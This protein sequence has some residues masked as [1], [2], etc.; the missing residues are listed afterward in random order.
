MNQSINQ[1]EPIISRVQ[2]FDTSKQQLQAVEVVWATKQSMNRNKYERSSES[3]P[4][5][6]AALSTSVFQSLF[7]LFSFDLHPT[8]PEMLLR[9]GTRQQLAL[10]VLACRSRTSG[11]HATINHTGV[12]LPV[13]IGGVV[14]GVGVCCTGARLEKWGS[15]TV[16]DALF[17]VVADR[18]GTLVTAGVAVVEEFWWRGSE[19]RYGKEE[20]DREV[21]AYRCCNHSLQRLSRSMKWG[22]SNHPRN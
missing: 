20:E 16:G 12:A 19:C 2:E 1:S 5:H 17:R 8:I 3:Y 22:Q 21:R 7:F 14:V 10:S 9:R 11:T 15:R 18:A 13:A 6:R 4:R